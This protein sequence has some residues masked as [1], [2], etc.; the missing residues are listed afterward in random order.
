MHDSNDTEY[1]PVSFIAN[2]QVVDEHTPGKLSEKPTFSAQIYYFYVLLF[3]LSEYMLLFLL[4]NYYF[5]YFKMSKGEAG[6]I[7]SGGEGDGASALVELEYSRYWDSEIMK[8][9]FYRLLSFGVLVLRDR[10]ALHK[11]RFMFVK[12]MTGHSCGV[13]V[14]YGVVVWLGMVSVLNAFLLTNVILLVH[15]QSY[16][17]LLAHVLKGYP[18]KKMDYRF[19]ASF[20]L[21]IVLFFIY[22]LEKFADV[23]LLIVSGCFFYTR[24]EIGR[25]SLDPEE[26]EI[27]SHMTKAAVLLIFSIK[28][29]V[30]ISY[31]SFSLSFT[32]IVVGL[33][34][35]SLDAFRMFCSKKVNEATSEIDS[36]YYRDTNILILVL[37]AF[38]FDLFIINGEYSL[39]HYLFSLVGIGAVGYYNKA[40]LM[41]IANYR[42]GRKDKRNELEIELKTDS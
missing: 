8:Y 9:F 39:W 33:V 12:L 7:D 36:S 38:T 10:S 3:S 14:L 40:F 32:D 41:Q 27:V 22:K 6:H 16:Y 20:S 21:F 37:I 29:L 4:R 28:F 17:K 35:T 30:N 11:T 23:I 15:T 26:I 31:D 1:R 34:V 5:A 25:V 13:Y 2:F 42:T 19:L 18:L 24:S